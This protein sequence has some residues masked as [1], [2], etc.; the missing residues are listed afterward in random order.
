MLN[1]KEDESQRNLWFW[2]RTEA[3]REKQ[4]KAF[5]IAVGEPMEYPLATKPAIWVY[6]MIRSKSK[7]YPDWV[8]FP[9]KII[10]IDSRI[11][12]LFRQHKYLQNLG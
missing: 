8:K 12:S 11:Y 6:I 1:R 3:I 4:T 10:E 5:S 2:N 7:K 9:G